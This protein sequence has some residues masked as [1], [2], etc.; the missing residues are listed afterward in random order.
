[1]TWIERTAI[2][3]GYAPECSGGEAA[4]IPIVP[5]GG[6]VGEPS[7]PRLEGRFRVG[8]RVMAAGIPVADRSDRGVWRLRPRCRYFGCAT[9]LRSSLGLRDTF[10]TGLS[11]DRHDYFTIRYYG[12]RGFCSGT[13]QNRFTGEVIRHWKIRRAFK[14]TQETKL[15][16][17]GETRTGRATAFEGKSV[18]HIEPIPSA[19]RRGCPDKYVVERIK[20]RLIRS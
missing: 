1:M 10:V 11:S 12:R 4:T 18:L 14:A 8:I 16:I 15:R 20:G 6:E 7:V 17:T 19:R 3:P 13:I 2:A 9:R 5:P